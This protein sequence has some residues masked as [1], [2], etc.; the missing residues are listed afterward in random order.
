VIREGGR[1]RRISKQQAVVKTIVAQTLKGSAPAANTLMNI[2]LRVLDPQAEAAIA[3]EPLNSE[4]REIL[5]SLKARLLNDA[6][7]VLTMDEGSITTED[8]R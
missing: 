2:H 1:S 7:P 4:E 6:Q 5:E 3:S 8:K